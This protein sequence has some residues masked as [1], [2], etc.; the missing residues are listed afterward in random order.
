MNLLYKRQVQDVIKD[1]P[2]RLRILRFVSALGLPD[3]WVAAGFVRSAVWDRQHGRASSPLPP[4]IDVIWFDKMNDHPDVDAA[5]EASLQAF[6]S[7]LNWSVKNQARMHARNGDRPYRSAVEAMKAWPETA[8]AVAVRLLENDLIEIAAPLGLEDLCELV[9]RPGP[10]F[11]AEKRQIYLDRLHS[12]SWQATWPK[13][14]L[15]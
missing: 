4:D 5:I 14:T 1:D 10:N 3:C 15:I 7:T 2:A 13:L 6:D 12:K 8:T 9:V 11:Q